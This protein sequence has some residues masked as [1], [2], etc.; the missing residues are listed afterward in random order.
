MIDNKEEKGGEKEK[1]KEEA[2]RVMFS[3]LSSSILKKSISSHTQIP[4]AGKIND[5]KKV[6]VSK[7]YISVVKRS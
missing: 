4:R 5:L 7:A 3:L 6:E 2:D 1:E